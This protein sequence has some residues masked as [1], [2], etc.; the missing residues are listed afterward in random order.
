MSSWIKQVAD[1]PTLVPKKQMCLKPD[2]ENRGNFSVWSDGS[3]KS[4]A[5]NDNN[6]QAWQCHAHSHKALA[7]RK[8]SSSGFSVPPLCAPFT[9]GSLRVF[10][11]YFPNLYFCRCT[12]GHYSRFACLAHITNTTSAYL[13]NG[14]KRTLMC[15][16]LE[17]VWTLHFLAQ[18]HK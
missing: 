17:S 18:L 5:N 7:E 16:I 4:N 14:G 10:V 15:D 13:K 12:H 3:K 1:L 9:L 8:D 6:N 2:K 11:K